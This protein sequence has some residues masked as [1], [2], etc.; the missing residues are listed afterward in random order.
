MISECVRQRW[1]NRGVREA[2]GFQTFLEQQIDN[3]RCV[4]HV[5]PEQPLAR[6]S[7]DRQAG[8]ADPCPAEQIADWIADS[9]IVIPEKDVARLADQ[10]RTVSRLP[11]GA[12]AVIAR[13]MKAV[14]GHPGQVVWQVP[15]PGS[16]RMALD[17]ADSLDHREVDVFHNVSPGEVLCELSEP[18]MGMAGRDVF[19]AAVPP[20]PPASLPVRLGDGVALLTQPRRVVSA[21]GGCVDFDGETLSVAQIYKLRGDVDYNV[22]NID[23]DGNVLIAGHVVEG[24]TVAATGDVEIAGIVDSASVIAGGN[25]TIGGGVTGH[26]RSVLRAGGDVS[27]HYLNGVDVQ[28]GRNIHIDRQVRGCTITCGG[29]F[30]VDRGGIVGGRTRVAGHVRTTCLGSEMYI[31]TYVAAGVGLMPAADFGKLSGTM[32]KLRDTIYRLERAIGPLL[33]DPVAI[34]KLNKRERMTF[35]RRRAELRAARHELEQ[36][37][38][39][40]VDTGG[41]TGADPEATIVVLRD[42]FPNCQV[43]IGNESIKRFDEHKRGEHK[44]MFDPEV[45]GL[46]AVGGHARRG[47]GDSDKPG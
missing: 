36:L 11:T 38:T 32:A 17:D 7:I 25:I 28:A 33:D 8:A 44:I 31:I 3:W 13:G 14:T 29:N 2:S 21:A 46:V 1:R 30:V 9:G 20:T 6:L 19:G 43:Q 23:F 42:I 24:F 27:A 10:A 40:V 18:H 12:T 5:D 35:K 41:A 45:N 15:I 16:H 22:G 39:A 34:K 4:I 37:E 26:G 47:V